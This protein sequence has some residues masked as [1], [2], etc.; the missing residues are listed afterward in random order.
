MAVVMSSVMHFYFNIKQSLLMQ[1][2]MV[3]LTFIESG[4]VKRLLLGVAPGGRAYGEL[5]EGEDRPEDEEAEQP[6]VEGAP[7]DVAAKGEDSGA[8]TAP[9]ADID[10]PPLGK[11]D[12]DTAIKTL[13]EETWNMGKAATYGAL[14]KALN[15]VRG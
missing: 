7:T 4:V 10:T 1:A 12:A 8:S 14:L 9:E 6:A 15:K 2:V 3:P 5:L 13:I 11:D